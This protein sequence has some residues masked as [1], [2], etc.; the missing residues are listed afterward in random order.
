MTEIRHR[1]LVTGHWERTENW[2]LSV[3]YWK[4]GCLL[5]AT[6]FPSDMHPFSFLI[7]F[8]SS[9]WEIALILQSVNIYQD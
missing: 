9:D 1:S 7:I 2:L 4:F 6:G 5:L 3:R 8:G